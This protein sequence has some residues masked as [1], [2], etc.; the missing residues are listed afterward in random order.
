MKHIGIFGDSWGCGEWDHEQDCKI[1]HKGIEQYLNELGVDNYSRPCGSNLEAVQEIIKHNDSYDNIIWIIS[2]PSRDFERYN[3]FY[4]EDKEF[5]YEMKDTDLLG[6][7]MKATDR[8]F[9][10]VSKLCGHK[11]IVVGGLHKI[12]ITK[13]NG[14]KHAINWVDLLGGEHLPTYFISPTVYENIITKVNDIE[15]SKRKLFI[16]FCYKN[17]NYFY[18]DGIHPNRIAHEI[19]FNAL[20]DM[21]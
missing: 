5:Y 9:E 6:A 14:F 17:N 16:D 20:K 13:I 15:E 1:T 12:D 7:C 3:Y 18:P 2:E 10:Q 21:I 19:L 11:T 4:K 8:H